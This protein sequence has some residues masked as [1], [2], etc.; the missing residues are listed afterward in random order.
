MLKNRTVRFLKGNG[1][2]W[3]FYFGFGHLKDDCTGYGAGSFMLGY[4]LSNQVGGHWFLCH[5]INLPGNG[6]SG[7]S[8][9]NVKRST[10]WQ[11]S[12]GQHLSQTKPRASARQKRLLLHLGHGT[13]AHALRHKRQK[14]QKSLQARRTPIRRIPTLDR[15]AATVLLLA[16]RQLVL[17]QHAQ[18][19]SNLR[20]GIVT[21]K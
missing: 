13:S 15:S 12:G 3:F 20:R 4:S 8:S 2:D 5:Q 14:R 9:V 19:P 10:G 17:Q 16:T 18:R 1:R 6:A 11:A 7:S 21:P